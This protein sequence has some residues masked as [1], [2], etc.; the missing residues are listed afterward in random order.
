M[1]R[2]QSVDSSKAVEIDGDFHESGGQILRTSLSLSAILQKPFVIRGIRAKRPKPGLQAQHLTAVKAC[3]EAC[4]AKVEGAV[5]HSTALS[6]YPSKFSPGNYSFDIGTAGS[7]FLVLQTLLPV[8]CLAPTETKLSLTGGTENAFAPT[9]FHFQKVF[10]PA[11]ACM[12]V[13]AGVEVKQFGW[14]PKGGGKLVARVLPLKKM[15]NFVLEERGVLKKISGVSAS[16][17]LPVH[18]RE[19]MKA[20]VLKQLSEN[21][22]QAKIELQELPAVGQGAELFLLAEYAGGGAAG[23]TA[24]GELGKPAEK[25]AGAA[26]HDF[27]EFNK[28]DSAVDLHLADQLLLYA[29]LAEGTSKYSVEK[30]SSHLLTNAYV[31]KKFLPACRIEVTGEEGRKG[32]V[33]V[34]GTGFGK[35]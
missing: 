3:A 1:A 8:A 34:S 15:K 21:S 22:L 29:A 12:G 24:L 28:T 32:V 31:I 23:F 11:V 4:G 33:E 18:V 5:L 10:L 30:I 16:S 27:L 2:W 35:A 17:N 14:Y 9:S 19:R 7:C 26:V 20:R 25:V 13:E 6:F